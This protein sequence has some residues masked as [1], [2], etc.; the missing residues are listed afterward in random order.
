MNSD[1]ATFL[2]N[3]GLVCPEFISCLGS[4]LVSLQFRRVPAGRVAKSPESAQG[5][6]LR[7]RVSGSVAQDERGVFDLGRASSKL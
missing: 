2:M 3:S 5:F 4:S 7:L 6:G 1:F